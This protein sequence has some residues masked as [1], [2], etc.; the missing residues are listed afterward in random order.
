VAKALVLQILQVLILGTGL[1]AYFLKDAAKR[2][3]A[4]IAL[5]VACTALYLLST[6]GR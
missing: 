6:A 3:T 4:V 1:A 2:R 5:L